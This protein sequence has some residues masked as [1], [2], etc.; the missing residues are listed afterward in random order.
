MRDQLVLGED[1]RFEWVWKGMEPNSFEVA[2]VVESEAQ[3]RELIEA[4]GVSE[5]WRQFKLPSSG[6][7]LWSDE[8]T[9]G[10][11]VARVFVHLR[12]VDFAPPEPSPAPLV[13]RLRQE[14]ADGG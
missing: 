10:G 1:L 12:G 14:A 8:R 11:R 5:F 3:L 6:N 4:C 13:E 2:C 9:E 7:L